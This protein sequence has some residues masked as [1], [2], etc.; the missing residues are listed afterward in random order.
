MALIICCQSCWAYD[1]CTNCSD[2]TNKIR[3]AAQGSTVY[4]SPGQLLNEI[5]SN[6]TCIQIQNKS[7]VTFD[8]QQ[9]LITGR[10][11]TSNNYAGI[12]LINASGNTVKNCKIRKFDS[13]LSSESSNDTIYQDNIVEDSCRG[14][15]SEYSNR[16]VFTGNNIRNCQCEGVGLHDSRDN[17]FTGN[18]I[19]NSS[20][21]LSIVRSNNTLVSENIIEDNDV[22]G[23]NLVISSDNDISDNRITGSTDSYEDYTSYGIEISRLSEGNMIINNTIERNE[24]GLRFNESSDNII[25]ANR[26]CYNTIFDISGSPDDNFGDGNT[27]DKPNGWEDEGTVGCSYPCSGVSTTSTTW[28][29]TST[30]TTTTLSGAIY[31]DSCEDCNAKINAS[32]PG[33]KVFLA[34]SIATND[35]CILLQNKSGIAL[36]CQDY[37]I[38]GSGP[39]NDHYSGISLI[40]AS[41]STVKNCMIKSFYYSLYT[42][43]SD[44]ANYLNNDIGNGCTAAWIESS[45][46]IEIMGSTIENC[47]CEG[48]TLMDCNNSV[49]SGNE[50]INSSNAFALVRGYNNQITQNVIDNND[51]IGMNILLSSN[52]IISGNRISNTTDSDSDYI[53]PGIELSWFCEGNQIINNTIEQNE[54][55]IQFN[56][57][58]GNTISA[59]R[60]CNN[61]ITDI[62]GSSANNSGNGNTCDKPGEWNDTGSFGCTYTCSVATTTSTTTTSSSTSSTTSTTQGNCTVPGDYPPCGE[63]SLQEIIDMINKWMAGTATLGEVIDLINAW[64]AQP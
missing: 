16:N 42:E 30:T 45:N 48:V 26:A 35:S 39:T 27:C 9:Y 2:C 38:T 3:S 21:A 4:L 64:A 11:R 13:A 23:I 37:T 33:S 22:I 32:A 18:Q 50:I 28:T 6:G 24:A 34:N 47:K 25:D 44:D 17:E 63:I 14:I 12:S 60:A 57:S 40:N 59:N 5:T 29:T 58:S 49:F 8:C 41:G 15:F 7:G 20:N 55:G 43:Y 51:V 61:T 62:S 31:C 46:R 53:S 1:I 56:E 36:D 54:A 52:N 19:R 10:G